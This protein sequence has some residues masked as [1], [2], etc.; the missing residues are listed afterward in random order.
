MSALSTA[1]RRTYP[2]SDGRK[3]LASARPL[4]PRRTLRR[5]AHPPDLDLPYQRGE[6]P[7][8]HPEYAQHAEQ[9]QQFLAHNSTPLDRRPTRLARRQVRHDLQ[10]RVVP[11]RVDPGRTPRVG[12]AV[13]V[14]AGLLVVRALV[15]FV[16]SLDMGWRVMRHVGLPDPDLAHRSSFSVALSARRRTARSAAIPG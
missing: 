7:H 9:H 1:T 15:A 6:L 5:G 8:R 2:I 16:D 3:R 11:F 12:G 10:D 13:L 4:A 14:M